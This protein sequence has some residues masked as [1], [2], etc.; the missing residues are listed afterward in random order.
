M[1]ISFSERNQWLKI[2]DE[3]LLFD[4][5]LVYLRSQELYGD[6]NQVEQHEDVVDLKPNWIEDEN[7]QL[8][9]KKNFTTT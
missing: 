2:R 3:N 1:K 6:L 4:E 5:Y 9:K 7:F 8:S